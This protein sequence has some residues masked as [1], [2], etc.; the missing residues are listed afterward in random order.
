MT[1]EHK[2]EYDKVLLNEPKVA[3]CNNFCYF[4]CQPSSGIVVTPL[5]DILLLGPARPPPP[6]AKNSGERAHFIVLDPCVQNARYATA[7][8]TND[9]GDYFAHH[10]A[11]LTCGQTSHCTPPQQ[12]AS[13]LHAA[14]RQTR[15]P[16][17]CCCCV[18]ECGVCIVLDAA[19]TARKSVHLFMF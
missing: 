2:N 14:T 15:H 18:S 17:C 3:H 6:E 7:G 8:T 10:V 1:N 4:V 5:Y 11:R 16:S 12:P 9:C 13:L 19:H